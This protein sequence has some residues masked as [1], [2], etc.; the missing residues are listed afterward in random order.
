[1]IDLFNGTDLWEVR[2]SPTRIQR[3]CLVCRG[4]RM[5]EDKDGY[6]IVC[7]GPCRGTGTTDLPLPRRKEC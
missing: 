1:M 5:V 6:A 2:L 3:V 7:P 4:E